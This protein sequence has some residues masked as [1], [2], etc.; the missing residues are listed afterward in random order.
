MTNRLIDMLLWTSRRLRFALLA[1]L[2]VAAVKTAAA[3][4]DAPSAP[5]PAGAQIRSDDAVAPR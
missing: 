3:A 5:A 1:L 4:L 2:A